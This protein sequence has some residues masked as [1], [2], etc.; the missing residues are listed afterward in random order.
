MIIAQGRDGTTLMN[1]RVE[2]WK[3]G[4]G[5][6]S[7]LLTILTISSGIGIYKVLCWDTKYLNLST[8]ARKLQIGEEI[9]LLGKF[10]IGNPSLLIASKL[11]KNGMY[12]I[13]NRSF[14]YGNISKCR[15][16]K[17]G[18]YRIYLPFYDKEL[19]GNLLGI[20]PSMESLRSGTRCFIEYKKCKR[21]DYDG[22]PIYLTDNQKIFIGA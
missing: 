9:S 12:Q 3:T 8:K 14:L 6:D 5:K 19:G 2:S 4:I 18:G 11:K 13:D 10:D 1:G 15:V 7:E 16:K 21:T 20:S 22:V 17:E